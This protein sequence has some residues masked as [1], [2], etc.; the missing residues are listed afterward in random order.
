MMANTLKQAVRDLFKEAKKSRS[1][2]EPEERREFG[3]RIEKGEAV[4]GKVRLNLQI[5]SNAAK[6]TLKDLVKKNGP[7]KKYVTV[8]V[9]PNQEVTE[10]N[11]DKLEE[12]FLQGVETSTAI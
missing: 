2:M 3:I 4:G 8:E 5:N 10:A 1:S 7:H 9:D 11:I 6:K 12:E